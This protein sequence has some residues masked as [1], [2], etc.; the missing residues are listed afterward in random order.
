VADQAELNPYQTPGANLE[1]PEAPLGLR[2]RTARRLLVVYAV[3]AAISVAFDVFS[4][5]YLGE[6]ALGVRLAGIAPELYD[7]INGVVGVAQFLVFLVT[8]VVILRWI[9][10]ARACVDALEATGMHFTPGWSIG[11]YFVPIANLWKPFQAL[12]EIWKASSEP[13]SWSDQPTPELL[14]WWWGFWIL[15]NSLGQ[16]VYRLSLHAKTLE[17]FQRLS[18]VS[19]ASS[20]TDIVLSMTFMAIVARIDNM[21]RR[22]FLG[23]LHASE[24][25]PAAANSNALS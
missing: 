12:N 16:A 15:A 17:E 5:V 11:W 10:R 24:G 13:R 23:S 6:L 7:G 21:Q 22:H 20:V 25:H 1:R 2:T 4:Y 3:T 14:R 9:Y 19:I 8:G 18:L